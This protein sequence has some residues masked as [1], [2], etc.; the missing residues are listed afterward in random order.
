SHIKNQEAA[1][2]MRNSALAC[3]V[4]G[5]LLLQPGAG[6]AQPRIQL[7]IETIQVG[8]GSSAPIAEFKSGVW[9]PF[10]IGVMAGPQGTPRG[11]LVVESVDSDDVPN[12]YTVP[13]PQLEPNEQ[14]TILAFTKPGSTSSEITVRARIDDRLVAMKESQVL[15]MGL[16]Q[17]LYL[18]VGSAL[19]G[20]RAALNPASKGDADDI[21]TVR[22]NNPRRLV[23][24]DDLRMLP[25]RWFAYE[26]VDLLILSTGNRDFVTAL[27]SEKGRQEAIVEWV[28][29]GG[30][31]L[32]SVGRNQ[33]I[34]SK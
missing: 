13:L 34:V 26:S 32:I 7:R 1:S 16:D 33:D 19:P 2:V 29:R 21:P 23:Q 20:L 10:Y 11:D 28:R 9:T 22:E 18:A 24:T 4:T 25:N 6:K 17:Q 3:V 5:L 12:R 30:R 14:E 8:F 15:A 27:R 31:L